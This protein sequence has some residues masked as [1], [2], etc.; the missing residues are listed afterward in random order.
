MAD[1]YRYL[2]DVTSVEVETFIKEQNK[3]TDDYLGRNS[4][5][6]KIEKKI[7]DAFNYPK[8]DVPKRYGSRYYTAMNTGL[9]NQKYGENFF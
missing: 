3:L 7:T 2:E 5:K 9:Q 6:E 4:I 1:P 8:F